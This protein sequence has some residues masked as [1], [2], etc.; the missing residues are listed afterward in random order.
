MGFIIIINEIAVKVF[1]VDHYAPEKSD[2]II[3][4]RFIAL[5]ISKMLS[6]K[7]QNHKQTLG[8]KATI[9][10]AIHP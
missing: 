6:R 7:K 2:I 9:H 10:H 5:H 1:K 4:E 3:Q 8:K